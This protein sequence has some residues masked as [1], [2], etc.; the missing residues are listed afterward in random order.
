MRIPTG[1]AP[2]N[3]WYEAWIDTASPRRFINALAG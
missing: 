2:S 3:Y 1:T